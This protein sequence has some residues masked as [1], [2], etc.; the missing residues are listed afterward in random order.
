MIVELIYK[1]LVLIMINRTIK[2]QIIKSLQVWPITLVTG[3]RQIGK[4]TTCQ[5][6]AK[7]YGYKYITLDEVD[8]KNEAINNPV[9]FIKNLGGNKLI[10]DEVQYA[11]ILFDVLTS[12]VNKTR[13]EEGDDAASGM[14][15]LTG[16][17]KYNL[18]QNVTQSMAGRVNIIE[19]TNLSMNEIK[20][21]QHHPF[22]IDNHI[23]LE[24]ER[25]RN[26]ISQNELLEI[27]HRGFYPRLHN[28]SQN[29]DTYDFYQNYI[30]SYINRDVRQ[31]INVK[32][33]D[34]FER[35]MVY[36]ATVNGQELVK[37]KISIQLGISVLTV[38][39]WISTLVAGGI[40][41]LVQPFFDTSLN[42]RII[43][44]NKLYFSDTGLLCNLLKIKIPQDIETND[45][46]GSIFETFVFN[47]INKSYKNNKDYSE[48][49]FYRDKNQNEIDFVILKDNKLNLVEVKAGRDYSLSDIK[50]FSVLSDSRYLINGMCILCST[51]NSYLLKNNVF[52]FPFKVI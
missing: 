52:A 39:S 38:E 6:I 25:N 34:K 35:F 51:N 4:S 1:C 17:Q 5:E 15:I 13:L 36:L 27:I 50:A 22:E 12:I 26:P 19:M 23:L 21:Y 8:N 2:E 49:F 30:N 33:A 31:L 28:N 37:D 7:Q 42:K 18:I 16:S 29:I 40:I 24:N 41:Y 48:I 43:K 11:P 47:E 20:G 10:I 46:K 14:F 45:Y 32:D 9:E 3:A 44:R